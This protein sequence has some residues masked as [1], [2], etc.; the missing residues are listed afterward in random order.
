MKQAH[1]LHIWSLTTTKIAL[2][3]HLTI[4]PGV[5]VQKIL[6]KAIGMLKENHDI[7]YTTLQVEDYNELM[8]NCD[9]CQE[10]KKQSFCTVM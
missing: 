5:N 9:V 8:N 7:L 1:S 6:D 10:R 3:A 4:E 2:S